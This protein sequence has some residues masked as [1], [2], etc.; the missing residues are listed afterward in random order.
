MKHAN[1]LKPTPPPPPPTPPPPPPPPPPR[2]KKKGL[3]NRV[4]FS[5]TILKNVLRLVLQIFLYLAVLE[6]NTTFDWLD[7]L[8]G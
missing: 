7:R 6:C 1:A 5:P 2:G 4:R 8:I 3:M